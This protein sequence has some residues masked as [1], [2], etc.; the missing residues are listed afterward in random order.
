MKKIK[1]LWRSI[2]NLLFIGFAISIIYLTVISFVDGS[3]K[4]FIGMGYLNNMAD[5]IQKKIY[6]QSVMALLSMLTTFF[7]LVEMI[8]LFIT[9]NPFI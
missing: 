9:M 3:I 7:L 4:S 8:R 6:Y 1:N 2:E 5:P